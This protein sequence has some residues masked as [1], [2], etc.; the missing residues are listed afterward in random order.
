MD[1][2][3]GVILA[4]QRGLNVVGTLAVLDLASERGLV[5]LQT[6]FD[7]LRQTTFRSPLRVTAKMLEQNVNRSRRAKRG[8][9]LPIG[10]RCIR[11][12]TEL[13]K[14]EILSGLLGGRA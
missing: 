6:M 12:P 11:L 14:V 7:R 4:R 2:R 5:D 9:W 8:R 3:D 1:D 13:V 10:F